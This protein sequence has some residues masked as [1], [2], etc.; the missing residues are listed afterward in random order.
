MFAQILT[1]I[2]ISLIAAQAVNLLLIFNLPPPSP[3]FY[4]IGEV[5]QVYRGLPPTFAER[6]PLDM[7]TAVAPP[8]PPWKAETP[9]PFA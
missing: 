4:R 5:V 8:N 2:S 3:D 6:R 1:L 9:K 7:T